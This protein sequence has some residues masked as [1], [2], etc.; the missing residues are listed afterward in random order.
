MREVLRIDATGMESLEAAAWYPEQILWK[1]R[2]QSCVDQLA[3]DS[4]RARGMTGGRAEFRG[5][6]VV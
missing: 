6:G 4:A 3:K 1:G 2:Q 5:A